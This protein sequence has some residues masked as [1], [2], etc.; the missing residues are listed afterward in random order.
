MLNH[1]I[2]AAGLRTLADAAISFV[3]DFPT[4][5]YIVGGICVV[6]WNHPNTGE[7]IGTHTPCNVHNR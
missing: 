2:I 7:I 3:G 1:K 4:Y 5:V 6:T